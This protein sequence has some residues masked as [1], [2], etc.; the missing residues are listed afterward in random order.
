MMIIFSDLNARES[1]VIHT[2]GALMSEGVVAASAGNCKDGLTKLA[3]CFF[4]GGAN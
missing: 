3:M 2:A 4:R 1:N